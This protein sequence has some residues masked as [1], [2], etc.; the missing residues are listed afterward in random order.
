M[1]QIKQEHTESNPLHD[2]ILDEI[3]ENINAIINDLELSK[4][5]SSDWNIYRAYRKLIRL[6]NKLN[7]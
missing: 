4:H 1:N 6:K 7:K 2:S 3:K 5:H